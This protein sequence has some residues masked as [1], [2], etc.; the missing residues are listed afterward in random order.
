MSPMQPTESPPKFFLRLFRWYCDPRVLDYIEGDLTEVY[1]VRLKTLGKRKADW[2]FIIEVLLLFRPG[3]IKPIEGY[4]NLNTYGMYKSYFKIGWRNLL[5][6]KGYSFI[7]IIGLAS[8]MTVAILIGLW[9]WDELSFDSYFKNSDRLAQVM[10]NQTDKDETYTGGTIAMPLG[11][12]LRTRYPDDFKRLSLISRNSDHIL[13]FGDKKLS[14]AGMWVQRD[15]PEMF[16]LKMVSGSREALKD[17]STVLLSAS[18]AKAIFGDAE[19]L[20]QAI[21]IDNKLDMNVGGVFEDLPMNTTFAS[22]KL[23]LPWDNQ[24]N[25]MNLQTSWSN[26]CGELFV[27]LNDNADDFAEVGEKIRNVPTPYITE[28]KEEIMLHPLDKLHLYDEFENGKAIGGRIEFVWLFGVIGAFVLLLACINFMNLSTA[29]SEKRAKEVGI[30][31]TIGSIRGQLVWQFL[32]ES[33][34]VAL[35][36]FV[37]SLV[38]TQL[39]LPFFNMMSEKQMRIP[40]SSPGFWGLLLG[41]T[42]FTGIISG[43]YP[44]FYLSAFKPIKVLKGTFRAGRYATLPRKVLVVVQFTVSITLI[45]ST[46]IVFRQIEHAKSRIPGYSREG[47][48]TVGINTPDLDKHYDVVKNELHQAGVVDHVARSSYSPSHFGSNNSVEWQGKDSELVVYF[49]NVNVTSEFGKTLGWKIA[50]GRDFLADSPADSASVIF[51][52]TAIKIMGMQNPLGERVKFRGKQYTVVGVT[53]DMVTQS[54]YRPIEPVM[55]FTDGWK[56]VILMRIN[57]NAPIRESLTKNGIRI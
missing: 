32:C 51:N 23:F 55:F 36:A 33:I 31:K 13:I 50:E 53:E 8:G 39:S 47:L 1:G 3:I 48:V 14:A 57:V 38:M 44:A 56:G 54:P 30:R 16:T 41:F 17:P 10:L 42:F 26:H 49:R 20:H 40:W 2:K 7:N 15:F 34:V 25:W 52:Q 28:I 19:P 43:S 46:V 4:K 18:V 9:I 24:E 29:R 11:D 37:F 12:A 45:I 35:L 27:Q 22:T 5:R 6:N 21:R